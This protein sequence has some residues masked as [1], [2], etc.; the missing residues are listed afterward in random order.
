MLSTAS[1][2]MKPL[3]GVKRGEFYL[4]STIWIAA[5]HMREC[6]VRLGGERPDL[7]NFY[8]LL[9]DD[10]KA[11]FNAMGPPPQAASS[12]GTLGSVA[13]QSLA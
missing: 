9:S 4:R 6:G 2:A 1:V 10:Q 7:K 13:Q 5:S 12:G 8:V 3:F 11:R